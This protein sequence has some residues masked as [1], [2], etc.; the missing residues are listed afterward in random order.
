[1]V[2]GIARLW[3]LVSSQRAWPRVAIAVVVLAFPA[4][5]F[6]VAPNRDRLEVPPG[7]RWGI[8]NY[9]LAYPVAEFL[10]RETKPDERI[11]VVGTDPEVYWLAER[12]AMTPL[13]DIFGMRS[14]E[15]GP[16]ER[17]ADFRR[18]PPAA[19]VAM[20][21]A[22]A[23]DPDLDDFLNKMGEEYPPGFE[24]RGAR[25]WLRKR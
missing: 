10:K 4:W 1:M 13:F 24:L 23:A 14:R 2:L 17:F 15:D 8:E 5:K 25:V 11:L 18:S 22:E 21:D 19:I 20:P 16:A 7:K 9:A 3:D 12:R 6:V